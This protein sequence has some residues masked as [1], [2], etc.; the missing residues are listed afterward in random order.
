[1]GFSYDI[2]FKKHNADFEDSTGKSTNLERIWLY[3]EIVLVSRFLLSVCIYNHL[4]DADR[5]ALMMCVGVW[6]W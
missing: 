3:E 4:T 5:C 1:M 2:N 6:W